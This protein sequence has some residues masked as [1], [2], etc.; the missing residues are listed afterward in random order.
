MVG[1]TERAPNAV[2]RLACVSYELNDLLSYYAILLALRLDCCYSVA[3]ICDLI[4]WSSRVTATPKP[5]FLK[6]WVGMYNRP[7]SVYEYSGATTRTKGAS[8]PPSPH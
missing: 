8:V 5:V 6:L 4:D 3:S 1:Q 2:S 7:L